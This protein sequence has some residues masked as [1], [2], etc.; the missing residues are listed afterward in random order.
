MA[1]KLMTSKSPTKTRW[2]PSRRDSC[3]GLLRVAD[4]QSHALRGV[5]TKAMQTLRL[6]SVTTNQ[7]EAIEHPS[8]R[9]VASIAD[10]EMA[11][12]AN[13]TVVSCE[14]ALALREE[15][16]QRGEQSAVAEE[17]ASSVARAALQQIS[18]VMLYDCIWE[19]RNNHGH[20]EVKSTH[21]FVT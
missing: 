17:T 14:N 5:C 10:R 16:H 15:L 7:R 20:V 6:R 3:M 4:K 19:T 21:V 13:V 12:R 8:E 9:A 18:E 1:R 11:T 2:G